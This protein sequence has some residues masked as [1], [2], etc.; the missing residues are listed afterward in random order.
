M[1]P[2]GDNVRNFKRLIEQSDTKEKRYTLIV[3]L[4]ITFLM[5]VAVVVIVDTINASLFSEREQYMRE[6]T[7]SSAKT[8][9][10]S[11][12]GQYEQAL[13]IKNAVENMLP[14]YGEVEEIMPEISRQLGI[15]NDM[16]F[17]ADGEGNYYSSDGKS[18]KI[19]NLEYYGWETD[20]EMQ[21]IASLPHL[22]PDKTFLVTRFRLTKPIMTFFEGRVVKLEYFSSMQ[23][24]DRLDKTISDLFNGRNNTFIFETDS[25][26][27]LYEQFGVGELVGGNEIYAKFPR[28][29]VTGD[30]TPEE[31]V[32]DCRQGRTVAMEMKIDGDFYYFC[33]TPLE[34]SNW[35]LAFVIRKEHVTDAAGSAF[36]DIIKAIVAF[37]LLVIIAVVVFAG[38]LMNARANRRIR[39]NLEQ[40]NRTKT[41]FLFNMSHDIRTPLNAIIGFTGIALKNIDN[42]DKVE[43]CLEKIRLSGDIL[44]AL[45]NDVLEFSRIE[46]GQVV[47]NRTPADVEEV[48]RET[49][50]V[51]R[52]L[53]ED[54]A[55]EL[56][57]ETGGIWNR[58]VLMDK[59]R[60]QR[61]LINVISNGIKYTPAGG[62]VKATLVELRNGEDRDEVNSQIGRIID[63]N[64]S[65][66]FIDR[67]EPGSSI[68]RDGP[69]LPIDRD[70]PGLP[71]DRDGP[72]LQAVYRFTIED[73]GIGMSPEFQEH[74]FEEFSREEN[75]T[76]SG[77]QG[78]GLG[79]ALS[80]SIVEL[81]GGSIRCESKQSEGTTFTI[82]IPF[83]L[84]D[85][86]VQ[87]QDEQE[88]K[89]GKFIAG[90]SVTNES[91]SGGFVTGETPDAPSA[92]SSAGS[93]DEATVN[94]KSPAGSSD[95]PSTGS[96]A[97]SSD[98]ATELTGRRALVVEDIF[99]N[100]EI[101]C[102][103]LEDLGIG[104]DCAENGKA[105]IDIL[106]EKGIDSFDFILMDIQ[107]PVMDGYEAVREIKRLFP[108]SPVPV[109]ALS[110]N[111]FEEDKQKSKAAGMAAHIAKPIDFRELK[112]SLIEQRPDR[113]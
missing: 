72:G 94:G 78:T 68:D 58:K 31:F 103:M 51:L 41:S 76:A 104:T 113:Y 4:V 21:Y 3:L 75:T 14:E 85:E 95:A 22:D 5:V 92:G 50:T 96:S 71:I 105:A 44:L 54:R 49:G 19:T 34:A 28:V 40:V 64:A 61:V 91:A 53:A 39:R 81:L 66:S 102:D 63:R 52:Q 9:N 26:H 74:L 25:G 109:I 11:I 57:F 112:N 59:T 45:I 1:E 87:R 12:E 37:A 16:F 29:E 77:V 69:G 20:S 33:S 83:E 7:E 88:T 36:N 23:D 32:E 62:F 46:S 13:S 86:H 27:M 55:V 110:A 2:G 108:D 107:M 10:E 18:G 111:A 73:N 84:Q 43:D 99:L 60:V 17:M 56:A 65:G 24:L 90:E 98:E 30:R 48:F 97:G 35:S 79:L 93:S 67:S 100:R 8:V 80:K 47:L 15:E 82:T 38:M 70:G 89:A 42:K 106:L 6:I 101:I